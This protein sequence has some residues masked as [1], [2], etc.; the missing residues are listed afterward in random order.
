MKREEH[1][2]DGDLERYASGMIHNDAEIAW[3][4][5][6]LYACPDCAERLWAMQDHLDNADSGSAETSQPDLYKGGGPLQ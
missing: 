6:H 4:E 3:I 2:S 1:L 5:G